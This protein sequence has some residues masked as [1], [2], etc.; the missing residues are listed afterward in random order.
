MNLSTRFLIAE[1]GINHNG[2]FN[3]A[4]NLI[5]EAALAGVNA[6]K[7]QYRN[8]LRTYSASVKEI[9]DEIL[10]FEIDKNHLNVEEIIILL[11][12]A[13]ELGLDV[14]IS[15]FDKHDIADFNNVIAEFDFFKIPSV[16]LTNLDLIKSLL[17]Y[18]KIVFI[19]TGAHSENEIE[20]TFKQLSG[21][22]WIPL[23]CVSNYPV[24]SINSKLGYIDYLTK[25]WGKQAGYSSHDENWETCLIAFTMGAHII[26][27][28]ITLDK[29]H[30]GLDHSTSSTPDEFKKL[31]NFM[32]DYEKIIQ[33]NSE[34]GIN[35]GE[36]IN[37]QNLGK[38]YFALREIKVGDI[39]STD[40]FE[41]RHPLV[42]ISSAEAKLMVG[43]RLLQSCKKGS[44]LTKAHF[45][46]TRELSS[47][48]TKKIEQLKIALPVRLHD[49]QEIN[50]N[51]ALSNYELH[52]SANDVSNLSNFYPIALSHKFS[53]HL[54]DY[55]NSTKLLDPFSNDSDQ[56]EK[57][58]EIIELIKVFA[59]KITEIQKEKVIIVASFSSENK[60]KHM[61]YEQ[62]KDMQEAFDNYGLIL[63]F[64]WL[65]PFAWYFGGSQKLSV[66]N[67]LVDI[68]FIKSNNLNICLDTSHL[69]MG[70][71][72]FNFDPK[73]ILQKLSSQIA[74]FHI[75]DAKGFDGEGY[76][77]GSGD[78]ENFDLL[79]AVLKEPKRKVIE[80][81][82]GHLN[83]FDGFF[84]TL[85]V[86]GRLDYD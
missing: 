29:R 43:K 41:Y 33:G 73:T 59:S 79:K 35:Q 17:K 45:R 37:K 57:S 42:G 80:T 76:I 81:W 77:I 25:R 27:R 44:P 53:V 31:S 6:V 55:Q 64:Q 18:G 40:D 5:Q 83:L 78:P 50:A 10:K 62:C 74:Q 36:L 22:N 68:D 38:T 58:K 13:K 67:D 48:D 8:L 65:P 30:P 52:L 60:D 85:E 54:P 7:F 39:F 12:F 61:F 3:T 28:H 84:E 23:H 69:L 26:E 4:K 1:I 71:K 16:E 14:G 75:S 46:K 24:L 19:S 86:I 20:E 32:N 11:K 2:D 72:Y 15:F 70:S 49:Y 47:I 56:R 82:Q 63:S 66:F 51:F 9:G 21:E 34:R